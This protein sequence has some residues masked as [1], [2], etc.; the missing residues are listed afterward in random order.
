MPADSTGEISGNKTSSKDNGSGGG[1]CLDIETFLTMEGG[2]ISRNNGGRMGGGIF[3]DNDAAVA[4]SGGSINENIAESHGGGILIFTGK[5][6]ELTGGEFIGNEAT[7]TVKRSDGL[8]GRGGGIAINGSEQPMT[9][10]GVKISGNKARVGGGIYFE[11]GTLN[12]EGSEIT[13]NT[14]SESGGAVYQWHDA[15]YSSSDDTIISDNSKPEIA[16]YT[17]PAARNWWDW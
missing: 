16:K 8:S 5:L 7:G 2:V 17:R 15:S 4:I 3:A 14:A 11:S 13:N 10:S 6:F 12:I 9:I 1:V